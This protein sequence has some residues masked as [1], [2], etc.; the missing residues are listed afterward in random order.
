MPVIMMGTTRAAAIV[1][2]L[3]TTSASKVEF[4]AFGAAAVSLTS[5]IEVFLVIVAYIDQITIIG[6]ALGQTDGRG[7][8]SRP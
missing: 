7:G 1:N 8:K 6:R 3:K 2:H 5:V 4:F